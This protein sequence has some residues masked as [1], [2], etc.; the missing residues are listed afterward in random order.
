MKRLMLVALL[1]VVA[2]SST[3]CCLID[4]LFMVRRCYPLG[5]DGACHAECSQCGG[6]ANSCGCGHARAGRAGRAQ[7]PAAYAQTQAEGP[8][9]QVAYPYYTNRGPRDYFANNPRS[10]GP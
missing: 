10:I 4:R 6:P 3:G 5:T 9:G 8:Q 7:A 2:G 1:T